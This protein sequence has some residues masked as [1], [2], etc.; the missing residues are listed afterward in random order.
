MDKAI[1]SGE[2]N[3]QTE[4][5]TNTDPM[6]KLQKYV[7]ML[8]RDNRRVGKLLHSEAIWDL[9]NEKNHAKTMSL[10]KIALKQTEELVN[11]VAVHEKALT[12]KESQGQ[13]EKA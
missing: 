10:L 2:T 1:K 12:K 4:T 13:S 3:T 6:E 9:A 5:K 7:D 11:W 8:G